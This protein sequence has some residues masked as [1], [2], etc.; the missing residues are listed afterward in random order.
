MLNFSNDKS[1]DEG[2]FWLLLEQL[3]KINSARENL[4]NDQLIKSNIINS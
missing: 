1:D 4:T 3:M 2:S